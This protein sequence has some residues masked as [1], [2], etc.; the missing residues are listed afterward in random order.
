MNDKVVLLTTFLR[1]ESV[2]KT[3]E[4]L[5]SIQPQLVIITSDGPRNP[6][7][8][9]VIMKVR[10]M[11]EDMSSKMNIK[12]LFSNSNKG[13]LVNLFDA[14]DTAFN[15]LG[16][17]KLIFLEDDV[18]P[19]LDFFSFCS[20]QLDYYRKDQRIKVINGHNLSIM[21]FDLDK[22]YFFSKRLTST[23]HAFWRRTYDE[24][25]QIKNQLYTI[26]SHFDYSLVTDTNY[27]NHLKRWFKKQVNSGDNV[28]YEL[29]FTVLLLTQDGFSIVPSNNL[30]KLG[31]ID[32]R[33]SNSL[34][35]INLYP[36]VVAKMFSKP[37]KNMIFPM[38]HPKNPMYYKDFDIQISR[39]L[40]EGMYLVIFWRR[41]TLLLKL[42]FHLKFRLLFSKVVNFRRRIS[43][44]GGN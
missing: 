35:D 21:D 26:I 32:D 3:L 1:F 43:K 9:E 17:E 37:I 38:N 12:T 36:K 20:I 23:A 30:V 29:L 2:Q 11:I 14:L 27:R 34:G 15:L 6:K 5:E 10:K 18:L 28:S 16:V 31:G 13:I 4:I 25:I 8:E 40:S 7:E 41:V 42:I 44:N 39:Q 19:S 33:A 24:L 22:D